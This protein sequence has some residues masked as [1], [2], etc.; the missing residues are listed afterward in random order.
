[1][2][3]GRAA[4]LVT[5][6]SSRL[7]ENQHL[8]L[9]NTVPLP[10]KTL[11][12]GQ[13]ASG[14]CPR[15]LSAA[16]P[17][18]DFTLEIVGRTEP[19]SPLRDQFRARGLGIERPTKQDGVAGG[20]LPT[21]LLPQSKEREGRAFT[22]GNGL[23]PL[24]A[25]QSGPRVERRILLCLS[26]QPSLTICSYPVRGGSTAFM[27]HAKGRKA[28]S[29]KSRRGGKRREVWPRT[30]GASLRPTDK[31]KRC[32]SQ[33]RETPVSGCLGASERV[34]T[35][36]QASSADEACPCH[37]CAHSRGSDCG[38]SVLT[39]I[40]TR[41]GTIRASV[42]PRCCSF[43]SVAGLN[44]TEWRD[45][46]PPALRLVPL[47]RW[48]PGLQRRSE[49]ARRARLS[50]I[51]SHLLL[52]CRFSS[53]CRFERKTSGTEPVEVLPEM[54]MPRARK[55][56]P[57]STLL[58]GRDS[59]TMRTSSQRLAA[60][61]GARE[62]GGDTAVLE[63][64]S[65]RGPEFTPGLLRLCHPAHGVEPRMLAE[66][67]TTTGLSWF[68][69]SFPSV[70]H[71]GSSS[72]RLAASRRP[73]ETIT[74]LDQPVLTFFCACAPGLEGLLCRELDCLRLPGSSTSLSSTSPS[75]TSRPSD[76][77]EALKQQSDQA[78]Q[79]RANV[80]A[81][82]ANAFVIRPR[83]TLHEGA[84]ARGGVEVRGTLESLWN[85]CVRSR[86]AEAVRI[87][88]GEPFIALRE[89]TF[90]RQLCALPWRDFV[91]LIAD[92]GEPSVSVSVHRSRLR[93]TKMLKEVVGSALK[94][95]KRKVIHETKRDS[96]PP[97]MKGRGGQWW[98][99][100]S[101]FW[102]P[103]CLSRA[104]PTLGGIVRG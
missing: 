2:P 72:T 79:A 17:A 32:G 65:S 35:C 39:C 82:A 95:N 84:T 29:F 54:P 27:S 9:R 69:T 21:V 41:E 23:P 62:D 57:S 8:L 60:V 90:F 53:H 12:P 43:S 67:G 94:E 42:K 1:M 14:G 10:R 26:F 98:F 91:P 68:S 36:W 71:S 40:G 89:G 49:S 74:G 55:C 7:G 38:S 22:C 58:D 87:R 70:A 13:G 101:S 19:A 56:W 50:P 34:G 77:V 59:D 18:A 51:P 80:A 100:R 20:G 25:T 24:A 15:C 103:P 16:S 64:R 104:L 52:G 92:L 73:T 96:L 63:D 99:C 48:E 102:N 31:H 46:F 28:A 47:Y 86:L 88:V 11:L 83:T 93:H 5:L 76:S 75:P 85:I 66:T 4:S 44:W 81:I 30:K 97:H 78:A 6:L 37:R 45:A 33:R 3:G 61:L